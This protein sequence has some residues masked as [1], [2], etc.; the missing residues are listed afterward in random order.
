MRGLRGAG[1]LDLLAVIVLALVGGLALALPIPDAARAALVAPLVLL[2]PGY[3][4]AAAIFLPG[5]IDAGLRTVLVLIFT[6]SVLALGGLVVQTAIALNAAVYAL[7]LLLVTIACTAVAMMRRAGGGEPS[8]AARRL[9]LPSY[10][11]ILGF[12]LAIAIAG[13]A[14]AIATAGEDRQLGREHFTALWILPHGTSEE[15]SAHIGLASH[16]GEPS[17]LTLRVS[18]GDRLLR[19]WRLALAPDGQWR[20]AVPAAAIVGKAPIVATLYR[21][22]R[23][24]RQVALNVGAEP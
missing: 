6:I 1:A 5:Q 10:A 19:R 11:S 12:L 9:A 14:I 24:F 13:W 20:G 22:A 3:A 23:P 21:N 15:F 2:L 16:E 8:A 18:Q 17:R 4:L 7:L